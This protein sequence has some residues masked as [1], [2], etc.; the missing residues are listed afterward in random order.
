MWIEFYVLCKK[1]IQRLDI[2]TTTHNIKYSRVKVSVKSSDS[3]KQGV[4]MYNTHGYIGEW[5]L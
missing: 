5:M 2:P 4:S 3:S 1:Y